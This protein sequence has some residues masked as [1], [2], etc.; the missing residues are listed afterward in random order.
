[1]AAVAL[2]YNG[3]V[4]NFQELRPALE[5]AGHR[6]RTRG[7]TEVVLRQLAQHGAGGVAAL[8]GMFAFA[9]WDGRARRLILAR[10]RA[11]I[12][13]LYYAGP[14]GGGLV[15]ASEP[16]SLLAHGGVRRELAPEGLASYFFSDYVHAPGTIVRGV[17]KLAP[18]HTVV[19]EDGRLE[20][21]RA[22]WSVPG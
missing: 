22:F 12:K 13:P 11:G 2:T 20:E 8:H 9:V 18:G 19:W 3:E 10:D 15:F 4:Y 14:D 7:D 5:G 6:F 21:P 16:T 1:D 17:R